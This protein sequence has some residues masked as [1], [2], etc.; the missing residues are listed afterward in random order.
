MLNAR[1]QAENYVRL[2]PAGHEPPPFIIVC[3]VGHCFEIYANFRREGKTY[4]QFPDRQSFRI[5]LEDLRDPEIRERLARD[6]DATRSRSTRRAR[7]ARVTRAIAER[8]AKVSKAWRPRDHHPEDVAMFLMRC[9][10]TMFAE[11]RRACCPRTPSATCWNAARKTRRSSRTMV[12]QLW[13]AM[14]KGEFAYAHRSQGPTSSTASSSATAT[15][16]P[17]GGRKSANCAA[18]GYDW[19]DVD[20]VDFRHAAGTGARPDRAPQARA[21]IT[22]RAP[23]SSGWSSPRSSSRCAPNGRQVVVDSRTAEGGQGRA[24]DARA[25][26]CAA[27][28]DKLCE[29]RVLDPACGTGNFLYVSLELLKRL[30]GEVLEALADLGGQEA[31]TGL[32]GHA[33]TRTSSS[34][35]R[36]IRAPRRSPNWCCGSA[37]CSGTSAPE[38]ACRPSRS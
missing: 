9:L 26:R 27:F 23:M 32:E 12:G 24:P 36:S 11:D 4:D 34:G 7:S 13:E 15:V 1:H 38:A 19:R 10:F 25:R 28:H 5:Y 35:W 8:L 22:R 6:L 31:L 20:P 17:L 18:A 30:E 29:T 2:L 37:I 33:S 3:D 16:L 21:R 14:D